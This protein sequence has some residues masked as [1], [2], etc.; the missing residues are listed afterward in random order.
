M[1]KIITVANQKGGVGKT[2][3]VVNLAACLAT[4]NR[5]VLII[6]IDA[7]A[8]STSAFGIYSPPRRTVYHSLIFS[9]PLEKILIDTELESLKLAPADK[10]LAGAVV[11]LVEAENREFILKS[12]LISIRE[13]FDYIFIDTPPSLNLLTINALAA[14]NSVLIPIQCEYF[15]L[16]GVSDLIDTLIR[17]RHSLNTDL[18]I[19]G[20]LLTMYDER[21]NLSN[22]VVADLRD[23]FRDQ[24]FKSVIPRNIRLAEAP[25]FGKPVILYDAK[26]K[27]AESYLNLAKEL[28]NNEAKCVGQGA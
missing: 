12:L 23:F 9:E 18:S 10:N 3:T 25:S 13:R 4:L 19:E 2:T 17:I 21:T 26:C 20:I 11:E 27:G 28:L 22:Q 15:A 16:E 7:Q 5:K 14:S 8:N 24:V 6:D 1:G